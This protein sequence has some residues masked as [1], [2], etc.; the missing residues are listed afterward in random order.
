MAQFHSHLSDKSD[1]DTITTATHLPILF[2]FLLT[3][4]M[5]YPFLKTMWDHTDVCV[6]HH[7]CESYIYVIS[8]PA[9][10]IYIIIYISVG[11]PVHGK[12]MLLMV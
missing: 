2:Q 10:K 6:K 9:Q 7:H 8:C 1:Q 12:Y 4:G 11:A 5:I 3:K